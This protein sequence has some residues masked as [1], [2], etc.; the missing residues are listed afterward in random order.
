MKII[1]FSAQPYDRTF[2]N[3]YNAP[4]GF[5]LAFNESQLN[6][7]TVGLVTTAVAV[8]VFVNDKVN[9]SVC[10]QLSE[11]GVKIICLRCAGFNNVDL[12]AAKLNG[13]RYQH[14]RLKQLQ[15]MLWPCCLPSI[16][17]RIKPITG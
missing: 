5:E 15:N 3:K 14:I 7:E 17:K 13:L 6:E 4:F 1:F 11:K 12:E 10:K 9:A 2:F 16:E 8:C